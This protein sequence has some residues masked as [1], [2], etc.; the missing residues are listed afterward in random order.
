[1]TEGRLIALAEQV[2]QRRALREIVIRVGGAVGPGVQRTAQAEIFAPRSRRDSWVE[3]IGGRRQPRFRFGEPVGEGQRLGADERRL[4]RVE[5]RRAGLKNLVRERQ[6]LRQWILDG[7]GCIDEVRRLQRSMV[8]V[9]S[10]AHLGGI[11]LGLAV[12]DASVPLLKGWKEEK[13]EL[14]CQFEY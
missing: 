10:S 5:R 2:E 1:V 6:S 11:C 14:H 7:G 12:L 4:E 13:C 9:G 3:G 8:L